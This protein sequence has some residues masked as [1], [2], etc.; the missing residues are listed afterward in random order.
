MSDGEEAA[1]LSGKEI[2]TDRTDSGKKKLTVP[3][4]EEVSRLPPNTYVRLTIRL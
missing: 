4:Y 1:E 3:N 2:K